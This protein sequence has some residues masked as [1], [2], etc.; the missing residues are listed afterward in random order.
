MAIHAPLGDWSILR[1]RALLGAVACA[2]LLL[3]GAAGCEKGGGSADRPGAAEAEE[4]PAEATAAQIA[5]QT[6]AHIALLEDPEADPEAQLRAI[7]ELRDQ[8]ATGAAPALRPFLEHELSPL[9]VAAAAALVALDDR[10]S[11]PQILKLAEDLSRDRDPQ[12]VPTLFIVA[13]MGTPEAREYL[14]T[15]AEAH[16]APAVR[17]VAGD[18]LS[19]MSEK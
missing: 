5:A 10:P 15:V 19:E 14:S 1:L 2:L 8:D 3:S 12:Y 13:D 16:P 4:H 11:H 18:A 6:A 7:Q 17:Q 9:R